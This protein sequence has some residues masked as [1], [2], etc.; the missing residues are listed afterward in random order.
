MYTKETAEEVLSN[1]GDLLK[2]LANKELVNNTR[3]SYED[4][5]AEARLAAL[6]CI[7][8]WDDEKGKNLKFIT[9]LTKSVKGHLK[10]FKKKN[11]HDLRV[12]EYKIFK[13]YN[14]ETQTYSSDSLAGSP[15]GQWL[16]DLRVG[17]KYHAIRLDWP[18][19]VVSENGEATMAESIP[20]G[21][22]S[23]DIAMMK[24]E[25]V[26]VLLREISE[27]PER[28]RYII[29]ARWLDRRKLEEIADDLGV[30][31]QTVHTIE[32]KAREKLGK[33]VKAILGED[34]VE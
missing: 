23:P 29:E 22:L 27:L 10:T 14:A 19:D 1:Y 11:Q 28:E 15:Y 5:L 30:K 6:E 20:S 33:R 21:D 2:S 12:T 17:N 13:D 8:N 26:E 24:Q 7:N 34:L 18:S 25:Q 4:L 3:Y 9:Y 31:K 32:K 16:S